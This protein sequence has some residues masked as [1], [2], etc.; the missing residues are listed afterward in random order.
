METFDDM[1]KDGS[2][3]VKEEKIGRG[4]QVSVENPKSIFAALSSV[5]VEGLNVQQDVM[6]GSVFSNLATR[7]VTLGPD[8]LSKDTPDWYDFMSTLCL[9]GR[10]A[11]I[12]RFTKGYVSFEQQ[13]VFVEFLKKRGCASMKMEEDK[14]RR[15]VHFTYGSND[16]FVDFGFS[17]PAS[18][19]EWINKRLEREK[20]SIGIPKTFTAVQDNYLNKDNWSIGFMS[21]YHGGDR[22]GNADQNFTEDIVKYAKAYETVL[23][24][25]YAMYGQEEPNKV[26]TLS[27]KDKS[28]LIE[29]GNL[30]VVK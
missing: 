20:Y 16:Y 12:G 5:G 2:D 6:D 15:G 22:S 24:G 1:L 11:T 17:N 4:L 25:I 26:L 13:Q 18:K 29:R 8:A 14:N 3:G 27:Y 30:R 21:V 28:S 23:K 7:V 10:N 9:K 19:I